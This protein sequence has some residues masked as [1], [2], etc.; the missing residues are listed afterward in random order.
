MDSVQLHQNAAD[1]DLTCFQ[2]R[3]YS[4]HLLGR[5]QKFHLSAHNYK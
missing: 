5:G 1:L 2:K 4:L 3:L